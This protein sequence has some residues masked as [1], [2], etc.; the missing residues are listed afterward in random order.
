MNVTGLSRKEIDLKLRKTYDFYCK[1]INDIQKNDCLRDYIHE[2]I[3]KDKTPEQQKE[4][5]KLIENPKDKN[6]IK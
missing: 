3:K 2:R 1:M 5:M 4:I 6:N